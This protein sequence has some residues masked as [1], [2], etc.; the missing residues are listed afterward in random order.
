MTDK[1]ASLIASNKDLSAAAA[2][3]V[4]PIAAPD[5]PQPKP[6]KPTLVKDQNRRII[7]LEKENLELTKKG[8][9][10]R[11]EIDTQSDVI[12]RQG[13]IIRDEDLPQQR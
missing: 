1:N 11:Q 8:T 5:P 4:Q 6:S 3:K 2:T 7:Q 9:T 13:R 12:K 10:Q